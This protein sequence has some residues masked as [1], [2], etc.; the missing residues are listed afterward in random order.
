MTTL[1][2]DV[3]TVDGQLLNT[4]AHNIET[5]TGH[6]GI[7]PRVG[8]NRRIPARHGRRWVPKTYD[9]RTI[10]LAMWVNGADEDGLVPPE[11]ERA[12]FNDNLRAL[13]RLFLAA[14]R[15]L[16]VTR[17]LTFTTG[18]ET[19]T[20]LAEV[21]STMEPVFLNKTF[22]RFTVDLILA[23]PWWYGP[24]QNTV[25]PVLGTNVTNPGDIEATA[26]TITLAGHLINPRIR[27]LTTN[28]DVTVAYMG[29]ILPGHSVVLDAHNFV[30]THSTQGNVIGKIVHTG[31]VFWMKLLP[32]LN[33]LWIEDAIIGGPA[34]LGTATLTFNPPYA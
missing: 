15:Q 25:V 33:H 8:E 26:L 12:V 20:C 29:E 22:A 14:D 2:T 31:D 13:K 18:Q 17:K 28:P 24:S 16:A 27:N 5:F 19:H 1:G 3:W 10:T 32:G 34:G 6:S 7:P 30:A 21:A 23:D 11:G 4:W 9:Q